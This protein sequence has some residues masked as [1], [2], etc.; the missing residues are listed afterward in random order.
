MLFKYSEPML[1]FFY[2]LN[3]SVYIIVK[4]TISSILNGLKKVLFSTNSLAKLLLQL[5]DSLLSA[6]SSINQ[7]P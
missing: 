7:S 1:N 3:L 4:N 5:L 2:Y 6:D